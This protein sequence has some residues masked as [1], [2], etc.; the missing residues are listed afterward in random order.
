MSNTKKVDS[1]ESEPESEISDVDTLN[2]DNKTI[3]LKGKNHF[4]L[5]FPEREHDKTLVNIDNLTIS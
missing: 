5:E 2:T 4:L 1:E 3:G